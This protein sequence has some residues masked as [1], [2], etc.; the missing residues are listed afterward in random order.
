M[1]KKLFLPKACMA[2][3]AGFFLDAILVILLSVLAYLIIRKVFLGSAIP[4][5]G[6]FEQA[7]DLV[8]ARAELEEEQ[9]SLKKQFVLG[10][11]DNRHYKLALNRNLEQLNL[12]ER[13]LARMG[14]G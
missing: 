6:L 10:E 11:L 12:V 8:D 2:A 3:E 7:R 14:F 5:R 4:K 9:Q 13:K 1:L